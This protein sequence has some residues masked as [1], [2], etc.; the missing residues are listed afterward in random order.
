M[1]DSFC[2]ADVEL[3]AQKAADKAVV[4][5]LEKLG[6]DA[7]SPYETQQDMQYVR[8]QRKASDKV[9]LMVRVS[10]VLTLSSGL[11]SLIWVGIQNTLKT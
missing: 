8:K 4:D 9:T 11:I 10:L 6:I 1:K 7:S 5:V 3:I 2:S